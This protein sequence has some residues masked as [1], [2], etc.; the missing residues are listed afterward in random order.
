MERSVAAGI[1]CA[2]ET[3]ELAVNYETKPNLG[4]FYVLCRISENRDFKYT[5][6]GSWKTL[7]HVF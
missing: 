3:T 2:K 5:L 4:K 6:D 7:K 1:V